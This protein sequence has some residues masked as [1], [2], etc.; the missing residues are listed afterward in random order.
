MRVFAIGIKHA[1]VIAVDCLQRGDA[2]KKH[3]GAV[4]LFGR[5]CQYLGR[6]QNFRM[7]LL[8]LGY[9]P[10]EMGDGLAERRK[11]GAVRQR[12]WVVEVS[13]PACRI[14]SHPRRVGRSDM[15]DVD[16]SK[17][18]HQ[19]PFV[20]AS[21]FFR[22]GVNCGRRERLKWRGCNVSCHPACLKGN[23][24]IAASCHGLVE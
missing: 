18:E 1:R 9:R 14:S 20:I 11:L 23:K 17:T 12:D 16:Q 6:G 24:K 3:P 7:A 19:A 10:G 4:S 5:M 13:A 22:A 15:R 8:R 21:E 2:R